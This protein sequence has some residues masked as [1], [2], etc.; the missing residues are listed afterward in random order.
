MPPWFT[1]SM[2]NSLL[3]KDSLME[4][5]YWDRGPYWEETWPTSSGSPSRLLLLT[6]PWLTMVT[7]DLVPVKWLPSHLC[8]HNKWRESRGWGHWTTTV[9]HTN[10]QRS[11]LPSPWWLCT[12]G[13]ITACYQWQR[14]LWCPAFIC[15][16][17]VNAAPQC[18]AHLWRLQL[19]QEEMI[20]D[21]DGGSAATK[22]TGPFSPTELS[23]LHCGT[24]WSHW[25][26][27]NKA[28]SVRTRHSGATVF[29]FL[30]LVW[31]WPWRV[32]QMFSSCWI[33]A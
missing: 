28:Q 3:T 25:D 4:E 22:E 17:A 9:D 13:H 2:C 21:K 30:E 32:L 1:R 15:E 11:V 7:L 18:P 14:H 29:I 27:T 6:E 23:P 19:R 31:S 16:Q 10:S 33:I 8:R 26:W 20:Q 12:A 5:T 24:S